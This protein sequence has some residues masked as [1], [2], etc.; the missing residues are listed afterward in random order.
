[1]IDTIGGKKVAENRLDDLVRRLDASYG[2][3]WYASGNEPNIQ[4]PWIY[5]WTGTPYKTQKIVRR[6]LDEQYSSRING[7]PG[8]D[9]LGSMGSWYVFSSIG[10]FPEIPGVGGFSVNSPVFEKVVLHL[11]GG[12]VTIQGGSEKN[13]YI[14]S[15]KL[16]GKPY[17]ST[18]LDWN[19]LK[20][21][22]ILDFRL[23]DKPNMQWGKAVEPHSFK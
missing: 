14:Q 3:D 9:D 22:A 11:P 15:M 20:S 6:I 21:G 8:N 4:V 23:S 10:L 7:L 18:W 16:N 12:K 5:N 19:D 2:D 1:L 17:D 13:P